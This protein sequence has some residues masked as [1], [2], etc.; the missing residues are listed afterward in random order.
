LKQLEVSNV[1]EFITVQEAAEKW[2]VTP[3]QV[4]ILCKEG[5]IAGVARMSRIWIIPRDA[6]KPTGDKRR[7]TGGKDDATKHHV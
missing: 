5:R 1:N 6:K 2:G 7:N 3:R 4:Q